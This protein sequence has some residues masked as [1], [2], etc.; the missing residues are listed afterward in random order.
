MTKTHARLKPNW[1]SICVGLA[2]L[3]LALFITCN[4][5]PVSASTPPPKWKPAKITA[6]GPAYRNKGKQ[7]ANGELYNHKAMTIAVPPIRKGSDTPAIPYG[8]RVRLAWNNRTI[9]VK[10]NDLCPG[11]TYDLSDKA[12]FTLYRSTK[13]TK[14]RGY[15]QVSN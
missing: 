3:T 14:L 6:Y 8:T 2:V 10:V 15:V 12:W 4:P 9:E 7:T 13:T 1:T 5:A 11:G